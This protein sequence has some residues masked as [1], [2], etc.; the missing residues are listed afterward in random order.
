MNAQHAIRIALVDTFEEPAFTQLA[1]GLF[2]DQAR[3]ELLGRLIPGEAER[4]APL[5]AGLPQPERVRIGAFDGDALVGWTSGWFEPGGMFYVTNSAVLPAYRRQG[6]YSRLV[7]ALREHVTARGCHLIHSKH[8]ADNNAV[9]I[10][11]LKLGFVI[12]GMEYETELGMLIK[13]VYH[14]QPERR[15]LHAE[16]I[17]ML[18]PER[19][20]GT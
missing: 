1:E 2:G 3:R 19:Y 5:R 14:V 20:G 10:A 9:I 12:F 11:K 4:A 17:G 13:M 7:E 8:R 18:A 15:A 6:V 16:R